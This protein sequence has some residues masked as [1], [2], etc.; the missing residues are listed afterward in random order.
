MKKATLRGI[1]LSI[2]KG[3]FI[4]ILGPSGSGKSTLV[5]IIAGLL[6][7]SAGSVRI[8]N[9]I[10]NE[11]SY[12]ERLT[13]YRNS[14]GLVFQ[15]PRNNIIWELN[16][17]DN[18]MLPMLMVS[19]YKSEK[20]IKERTA[21]LIKQVA[22]QSRI[23]HKPRQLSGGELQRLSVAIAFSNNPELLI[24]DEPTSQLD[25]NHA[26]RIVNFL[27]TSCNEQNKT[28][29]MVTHDLRMVRRTDHCF[30]MQEGRLKEIR[31]N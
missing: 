24:L 1:H 21:T 8:G 5:K 23:F 13:F 3:E 31:F 9:Q 17:F 15:N 26:L 27:R 7:P 16:V 22:L 11:F 10:I 12:E 28:I 29:F 25:I 18:V 6:E 4:S 14:I 20:D 30:K 19:T 2:N